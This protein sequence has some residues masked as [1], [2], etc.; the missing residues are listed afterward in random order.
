MSFARIAIFALVATAFMVMP[1]VTLA[2]A[3]Q[4]D[5][6]QVL[7][8]C[9]TVDCRR[10]VHR[11]VKRIRKGGASRDEM[12]SQIGILA[13]TVIDAAKDRPRREVRDIASSL[14]FMSAISTDRRQRLALRRAA[15][16][17][18]RGRANNFDTS[19]PWAVSPA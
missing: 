14:I 1:R 19:S 11:V 17:V 10:V 7:D 13:G 12:N 16:A 3:A 2:Q 15:F 8:R 5:T 6:G 4:F 18:A 9:Q